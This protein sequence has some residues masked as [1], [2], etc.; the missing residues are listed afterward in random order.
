MS[1]WRENRRL[2]ALAATVAAIVVA[3]ILVLGREPLIRGAR[4]GNLA[5]VPLE[6]GALPVT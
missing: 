5:G 1:F 4:S 2:L 3:A 6:V